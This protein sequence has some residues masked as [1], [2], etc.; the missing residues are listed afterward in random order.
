MFAAH[1][2]QQKNTDAGE[3]ACA[4]ALCEVGMREENG[5]YSGTK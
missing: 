4:P 2:H 3:G 1:S 5:R